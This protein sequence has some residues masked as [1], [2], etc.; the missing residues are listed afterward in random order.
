MLAF[1]ACFVGVMAILVTAELLWRANILR[2][3]YQRK[4]VHVTAGSFFAFWPWLLSW[5]QIELMGVL[6]L[7]VLAA[8]RFDEV[9]H[10]SADLRKNSIGGACLAL[11]VIICALLTTDKVFFSVAM[12][13]TSLADGFAALFGVKFGTNWQY[14][15]FGQL[16]S[17]VGT[18]A[19]WLTSLLILGAGLLFSFSQVPPNYYMPLLAGMPPLLAAVENVT[20]L[21]LDNL[22]VPVVALLVLKLITA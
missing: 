20:P 16:K 15:A 18:M 19:F 3:E 9:L 2:G 7:I 22:T 1:I 10:Y 5:H 13:Q 21:G 8:N 17:V 4:F 12:L 14:K 6:M 11:A